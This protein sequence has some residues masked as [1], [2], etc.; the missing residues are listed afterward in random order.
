MISNEENGLLVPPKNPQ[1]L[2]HSILKLASEPR[3]RQKYGK[4]A[5]ETVKQFDK[6]LMVDKNLELY[7]TL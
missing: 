7:K 4:N 2:S 6:E 3:L 5:L 1:E